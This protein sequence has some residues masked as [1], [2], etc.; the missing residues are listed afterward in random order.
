[1]IFDF[2]AAIEIVQIEIQIFI[3]YQVRFLFL[4]SQGIEVVQLDLCKASE[5]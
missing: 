1:M 3:L 5:D 4:F 2:E